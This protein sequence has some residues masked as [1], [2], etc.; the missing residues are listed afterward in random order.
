MKKIL[1]VDYYGTCN[2]KGEP[3]G[4]SP[5]VLQEYRNL[6]DGAFRVSAAVSPCIGQSICKEE[7]EEIMKLPYDIIE[8][9]KK[10]IW[11]RIKDKIKLIINI[12]EVMKEKNN[13]DIIWFY[14]TDFF[15]FFYFYIHKK[16]Q[17]CKIYGLVYHQRFG[18]GV[19]G[20][21]LSW[22]YNH[23][24]R[25]FSG[26]VYTQKSVPPK[27]DNILYIPDY[28]YDEN[29]YK[30]YKD[31][32]KSRKA[33][34]LGTMSP[35]K[36]LEELIE[37]FNCLGYPL[38]V[39]GYFFEEDRYQKLCRMAHSNIIIQ[40]IILSD[41]DYYK[42]LAEAK[43]AVLP[44]DMQ[45]YQSRTS[46]ILQE[47]LFLDTIP[48]APADLLKNNGIEG[49]GYETMSQLNVAELDRRTGIQQNLRQFE[50]ENIKKKLCSF[51]V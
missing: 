35:Y 8:K 38:E 36:K 20:S 13:F 21:V 31:I 42:K 26:L 3:I 4:H 10:E 50:R 17:T 23:S 24:M 46:G 49:Y 15:L 43:Y 45:Q 30:K 5:K 25:K 32:S 14:R 28:Y 16:V 1:L 18:E 47:C 27:H 41:E 51:L 44:Y 19:L 37:T 39:A 29:K 34:C 33:V 22:I 12:K 6:L 40:N 2:D 11:T 9:G 7:Y 48:I